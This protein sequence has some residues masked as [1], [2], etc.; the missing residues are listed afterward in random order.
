[1][2]NSKWGE[3]WRHLTSFWGE[4]QKSKQFIRNFL[5]KVKIF[6]TSRSPSLSFYWN[7]IDNSYLF[8]AFIIFFSKTSV[9]NETRLFFNEIQKGPKRFGWTALYEYKNCLI[10][11][12]FDSEYRIEWLNYRYYFI[13]SRFYLLNLSNFDSNKIVRP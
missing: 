12:H 8:Y 6:P 7:S 11:G 13:F 9:F 2:Q 1:M 4:V 10:P 3:V 5:K